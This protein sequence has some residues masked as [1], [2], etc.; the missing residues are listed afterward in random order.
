MKQLYI[1]DDN[2]DFAE[3]LATVALQEGWDVTTS[4][5]GKEL[6]KNLQS[7]SGPA[8][9]LVDV[10]MPEMDGIESIEKM[11]DID[12]PLR[13]RFITGGQNASI[14]AA[15]MIASARDLTVGRSIYKPISMKEFKQL[16][17]EEVEALERLL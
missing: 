5:N 1:A 7:G 2:E 9:V 10:N 12:R 13:V 15:R 6:I 3:Y 11:V 16:L 17:A 8:F 4:A 14:V